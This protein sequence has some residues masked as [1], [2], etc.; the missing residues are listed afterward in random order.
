MNLC[1][2][3]K[4]FKKKQYSHLCAMKVGLNTSILYC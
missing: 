4:D 3:I 1:N 2:L